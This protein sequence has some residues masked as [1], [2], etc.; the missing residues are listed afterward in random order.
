[1]IH[2][3]SATQ[4]FCTKEYSRFNMINGNRQ[5]NEAKIKRIIKEIENGCNLLRYCPII[6]CVNGERLNIVDGQHRFWVSKQ[7]KYPVWYVIAD[8]L[9]LYDIAKMNSNTEKWKEKDYINCYVQLGNEH[10][11]IL[12]QTIEKYPVAVTTAI[13]LLATGKVNNGTRAKA[14]FEQGKF[15]VKYGRQAVE[16]LDKVMVINYAEKFNRNFLLAIQVIDT[17]GKVKFSDLVEKI[18]MESEDLRWQP[19]HKSYLVHLEQIFNKGK[20]SRFTIY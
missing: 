4:I 19:D 5:L 8:E 12:R 11:E 7:L 13:S 14:S 9:S 15:E 20:H 1:M 6:V 16:F 3:E 17:S 2:T 18:N 10:Y